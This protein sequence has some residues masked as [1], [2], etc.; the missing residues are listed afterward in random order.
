MATRRLCVTGL[1]VSTY[2]HNGPERDEHL[3]YTPRRGMGPFT[4][5][6]HYTGVCRQSYFTLPRVFTAHQHSSCY[7]ERCISYDRFR[8]SVC[9]SQSGIMSKRLKLR[10]WGLHCR[11]APPVAHLRFC[12]LCIARTVSQL[13]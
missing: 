2:G 3:A 11:I 6:L 13:K 7:A 1:V 4:F 8:P 10:S 12:V 9:P 5:T